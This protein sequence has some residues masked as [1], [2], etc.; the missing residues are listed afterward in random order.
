MSNQYRDIIL[1]VEEEANIRRFADK[2][3]TSFEDI[4]ALGDGLRQMPIDCWIEKLL[5]P[6]HSAVYDD[7]Q[8]LWIVPDREHTG[9]GFGFIAIR[10]DRSWFTGVVPPEVFQ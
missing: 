1:H 5:G 9:P 4:Q 2:I 7:D 8:D 6:D 10:S 3:G